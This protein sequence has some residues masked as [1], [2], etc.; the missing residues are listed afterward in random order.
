MSGGWHCGKAQHDVSELFG[1]MFDVLKAPYIP[2]LQTLHHS[3]HPSPSD[4]AA[5]TERVL[6]LD[7][8]PGTLPDL[9]HAYCT[10][11]TI[12]GLKRGE[13]GVEATV[14]RS[15]IPS[16]TPV[17]ETGER[18]SARRSSFDVLMLPLA[19]RRFNWQGKKNR[20]RIP[21]ATA[22]NASRYINSSVRN[23]PYN[24]I[25]RSVI[26][27]LGSSISHGHYVNYTYTTAMGWRRWDDLSGSSVPSC[28]G[29][30]ETGA[31]ENRKWREELERDSYMLF[32][33][34]VPGDG[35]ISHSGRIHQ[36]ELFA[37]KKQEEEDCVAALREQIVLD[38]R[39]IS[40]GE[41]RQLIQDGMQ[42]SS[43]DEV[44]HDTNDV[45]KR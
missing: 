19:L 30:T 45:Y 41:F 5:F 34:L 22:I 17:R 23:I 44:W 12:S 37:R 26:C 2:L 11:S 36:D 8:V 15:L 14:S 20:T 3:A 18:S 42:A 21:L 39:L 4:N 24:L 1:Y 29:D 40:D 10:K 35:E 43:E 16:Y 38:G 9:L 32:Y 31:P 28:K 6:F 7:I 27:H 13:R 33:E 25:L